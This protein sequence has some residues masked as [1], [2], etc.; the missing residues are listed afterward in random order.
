[1]N[2]T[3]DRLSELTKQRVGKSGTANSLLAKLDNAKA[4]DARGSADAKAGMIGASINEVDAQSGKVIRP[5]N[6]ASC[7]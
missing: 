6:A 4:A 5:E 7:V 2:I 1:M 3:Y